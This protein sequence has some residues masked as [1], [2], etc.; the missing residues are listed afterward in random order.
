MIGM[1]PPR[2]GDD[3]DTLR[4]SST[5]RFSQLMDEARQASLEEVQPGD[6]RRVF[7]KP[8]RAQEA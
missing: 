8:L 3:P 2:P 4:V 5:G 1:F 6:E 7:Y